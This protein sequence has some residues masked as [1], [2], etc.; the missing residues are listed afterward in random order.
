MTAPA[1]GLKCM[2]FAVLQAAALCALAGRL[3]YSPACAPPLRLLP[4]PGPSLV[5]ILA[6]L[7][8]TMEAFWKLHVPPP[9]LIPTSFFPLGLPPM[10]SCG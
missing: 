7:H 2:G 5:D 9:D 1:Q 3:H 10:P 8:M 4:F 6:Q